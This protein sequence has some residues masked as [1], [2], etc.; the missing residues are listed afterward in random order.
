MARWIAA[1]T[2]P[3][4]TPMLQAIRISESLKA[5]PSPPSSEFLRTVITHITARFCSDTYREK[6]AASW[7]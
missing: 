4:V 2:N 7:H 5:N 1:A 6:Y 3:G